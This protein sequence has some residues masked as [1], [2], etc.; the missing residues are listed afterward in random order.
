MST[1]RTG[2]ILEALVA[3]RRPLRNATLV[4]MALL[5]LVDLFKEPAYER[6]PWD[7]IGGFI[8]FYGFISCVLIIV[9]SKA[10]GYA[11][12]YRREDYYDDAP[13]GTGRNARGD[14]GDA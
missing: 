7:G 4:V 12:L 2:R 1:G 3:R 5:V 14:D 11:F 8:A 13:Q 9:V 6:F 10:L